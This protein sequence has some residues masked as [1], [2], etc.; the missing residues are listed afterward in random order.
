MN[1]TIICFVIMGVSALLVFVFNAQYVIFAAT[2]VSF[3]PT[4]VRFGKMSFTQYYQE[5]DQYNGLLL[6]SHPLVCFIIF[7]FGAKLLGVV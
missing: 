7:V 6:F 4:I 3:I 2:V 1:M 5:T